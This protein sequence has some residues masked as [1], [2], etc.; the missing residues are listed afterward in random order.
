M[1][2]FTQLSRAAAENIE[3]EIVVASGCHFD[4]LLALRIV[5]GWDTFGCCRRQSGLAGCT[6][7]NNWRRCG[8]RRADFDAIRSGRQPLLLRNEKLAVPKNGTGREQLLASDRGEANR[9]LIERRSIKRH[10]AAHCQA[11]TPRAA[12]NE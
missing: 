12:P 3:L 5:F 2:L 10:L 9:S 1:H 8:I 11:V 6:L 4:C 7:I